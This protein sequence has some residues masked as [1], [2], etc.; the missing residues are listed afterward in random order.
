MSGRDSGR[1]GH[2]RAA[3]Q[4]AEQENR[5]HRVER[6]V[7]RQPGRLCGSGRIR[8]ASPPL[9]APTGQRCSSG[10]EREA[11]APVNGFGS[12]A[13]TK[14]SMGSVTQMANSRR[15]RSVRSRSTRLS[16]RD[17]VVLRLAISW[18]GA[19]SRPP[20]VRSGVQ[21]A[22]VR[23]FHRWSGAARGW[24]SRLQG[25]AGR[26][27]IQTRQAVEVGAGCVPP[28]CRDP[29]PGRQYVPAV[30][31]SAQ[32]MTSAAS[33][34]VCAPGARLHQDPADERFKRVGGDAAPPRAKPCAELSWVQ[35]VGE[36]RV[37][38]VRVGADR[39]A[40][41]GRE[42]I[43]LT[44]WPEQEIRADSNNPADGG[45]GRARDG[46]VPAAGVGLHRFRPAARPAV[47]MP[48]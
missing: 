20:S 47:S 13:P 32:A 24:F 16:S 18:E 44:L 30:R 22:Q 45:K 38:I 35:Q 27:T 7:Q 41:L 31:R 25:R 14:P 2:S 12:M 28:P 19:P 26:C 6:E 1:G 15:S 5:V 17:G 23:R 39:A 9:I 4:G 21:F 8:R 29:G 34:W 33:N 40:D 3:E 37:G 48:S 42:Q 46:D 11:M 43:G 10:A 36:R